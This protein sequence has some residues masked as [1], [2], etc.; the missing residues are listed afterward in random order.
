MV[1]AGRVEPD[2]LP[3]PPFWRTRYFAF[4]VMPRRPDLDPI[5]I[6]RIVDH[7]IRQILQA[8]GRIRMYR[9]FRRASIVT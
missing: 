8:D 6:R 9:L 4:D 7:P 1:K 2:R 3:P 5:E